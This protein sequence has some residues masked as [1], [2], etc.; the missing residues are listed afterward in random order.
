MKM[1]QPVEAMTEA[2]RVTTTM[3]AEPR[4]RESPNDATSGD[5]D[6][7]DADDVLRVVERA[8]V[9]VRKTFQEETATDWRARMQTRLQQLQE[10]AQT[11]A[12]VAF[13]VPSGEVIG[14]EYVRAGGAFASLDCSISV[15]R[16]E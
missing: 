1:M 2:P 13:R 15:E 6:E 14:R 16:G 4:A 8:R 5:D 12:S 10:S 9:P 3:H 7:M 11:R